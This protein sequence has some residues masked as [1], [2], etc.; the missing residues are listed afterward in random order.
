MKE[1]RRNMFLL[2]STVEIASQPLRWFL[3][4]YKASVQLEPSPGMV[5]SLGVLLSPTVK[6]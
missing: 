3:I 2:E 5:R 6:P 1:R 4:K